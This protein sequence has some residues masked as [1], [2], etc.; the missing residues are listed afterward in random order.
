M[1]LPVCRRVRAMPR[2]RYAC[3][4]N[5]ARDVGATVMRATY[6]VAGRTRENGVV[7]VRVVSMRQARHQ[8]S[9]ETKGGVE[10]GGTACCRKPQRAYTICALGR[11][12]RVK[13]CY[14]RSQLM[15]APR[16]QSTVPLRARWCAQPVRERHAANDTRCR[17]MARVA[18]R[19][20]VCAT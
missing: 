9:E 19:V 16:A 1:L 17:K 4:A 18:R 5:I 7:A 6:G 13:I 3:R 20:R 15:R 2:Q 14:Q 8:S 12:E 11:Q 10:R